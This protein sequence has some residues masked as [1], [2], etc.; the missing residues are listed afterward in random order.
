[1]KDIIPTPWHFKTQPKS[2][3]VP[4]PELGAIWW[5]PSVLSHEYIAY[6]TALRVSRLGARAAV[7]LG[8][9][10]RDLRGR[11]TTTEGVAR[12]P[13][14]SLFPTSGGRHRRLTMPRHRRRGASYP[15]DGKS[16][17]I[18]SVFMGQHTSALVTRAGLTMHAP[19][20]LTGWLAS[21][22]RRRIGAG[23]AE[24]KGEFRP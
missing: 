24:A 4:V 5:T 13:G 21:G 18:G 23:C 19:S 16:D 8:H 22:A 15:A 7:M 3:A 10:P 9:H 12:P 17:P 14:G 6:R 1:M 11:A 2:Q 20:P